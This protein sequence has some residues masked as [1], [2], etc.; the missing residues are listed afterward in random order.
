[1]VRVRR[2]ERGELRD[3]V[4]GCLAV[5]GGL[6]AGQDLRRSGDGIPESQLD[7]PG[8]R[9]LGVRPRRVLLARA[10]RWCVG[11]VHLLEQLVEEDLPLLSFRQQRPAADGGGEAEAGVR[12]LPGLPGRRRAVRGRP[13]E[14]Q[15]RPEPQPEGRFL[16]RGLVGGQGRSCL[17]EGPEQREGRIEDPAL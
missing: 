16:R 5:W 9:H 14:Q 1:M 11:V 3:L 10:D 13:A 8:V 7:G 4:P 6:L 17:P 12:V 15:G 2:G